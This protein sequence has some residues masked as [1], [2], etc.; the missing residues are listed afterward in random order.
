MEEQQ[1]YVSA[2]SNILSICIEELKHGAL[3][4]KQSVQKNIQ[5]QI[6][7]EPQGTD[8]L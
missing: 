6:L 7:S 3:I 1:Y 4:W 8:W 5:S 2:W